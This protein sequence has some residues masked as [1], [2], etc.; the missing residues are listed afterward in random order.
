MARGSPIGISIPAR[1]SS[2]ERVC[3]GGAP[4]A[5][6][7]S[8][9]AWTCGSTGI[10]D[11]FLRYSFLLILTIEALYH[12]IKLAF[13]LAPTVLLCIH[14]KESAILYYICLPPTQH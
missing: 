6:I 11:S 10:S 3:R 9:T 2:T 13:K 14:C 12:R 8:S 1:A 7:W 5:T 4:R